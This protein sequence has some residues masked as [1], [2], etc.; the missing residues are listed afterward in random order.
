ML[1]AR[2]KVLGELTLLLYHLPR[3]SG[4]QD[5]LQ[6]FVPFGNS[7]S[8]KVFVDNQTMGTS[9]WFCELQQFCFTS[10]CYASMKGFQQEKA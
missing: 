8:A 2:R 10:S 4:A 9:V 7:G 5:L 1:E 6:M 3:D